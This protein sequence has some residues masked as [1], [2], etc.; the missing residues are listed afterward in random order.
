MRTEHDSWDEQLMLQ[1]SAA[2]RAGFRASRL[3]LNEAELLAALRTIPDIHVHQV[4]STTEFPANCRLVN[5][6]RKQSANL[7][8]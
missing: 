6:P 7:I 2:C 1:C 4:R 5:M 8:D 3:L